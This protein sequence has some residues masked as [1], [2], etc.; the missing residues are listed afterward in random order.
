[1]A[2][3]EVRQWSD[4][5]FAAYLVEDG[6]LFG[7]FVGTAATHPAALRLGRAVL[8]QR[9]ENPC[10]TTEVGRVSCSH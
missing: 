7:V 9:S 5:L 6:D 10:D 3:V 2:D 1:M 8:R 4:R